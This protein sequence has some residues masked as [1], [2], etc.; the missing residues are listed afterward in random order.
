MAQRL[1]LDRGAQVGG[2]SKAFRDC[3]P[4]LLI[5]ALAQ[6]RLA[7]HHDEVPQP[8]GQLEHAAPPDRV[9]EIAG[10]SRHRAHR[11]QMGRTGGPRLILHHRH[12][13]LTDHPHRSVRP[14]QLRG[15]LD[16]VVAVVGF[17]QERIEIA[18]RRISAAGILHH[19]DITT[20]R[21]I[22]LFGKRVVHA[23]VIRGADHEDR[24]AALRRRPIDV[25][26]QRHAV[27]RPHRQIL[28]D[29]NRISRFT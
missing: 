20:G 24:K 16:S 17:A 9:F 22:V 5:S 29:Y 15:P 6:H 26:I 23:P 8:V 19:H 3:R 18:F 10:R 1:G 21:K 7:G 11:P 2:I 25:G 13:R 4:F 27:A 12:V 14:G 28:F